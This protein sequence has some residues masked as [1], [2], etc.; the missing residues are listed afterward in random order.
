VLSKPSTPTSSQAS[1][2]HPPDPTQ[3]A[4][5]S[6]SPEHNNLHEKG[7]DWNDPSNIHNPFN[8]PD[9][10]KWRVTLLAS[11]MT[12]VI[13]ANG[14]MMTSAAQQINKSFHISDEAFPHSYWPVLS[15][16]LGGA[17]APMIGLPLRR[18][19]A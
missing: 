17:A 5:A 16:N 18:N 14:T 6:T 2:L 13:Q 4:Q 3:N 12:F 7:L 11:F 10:K 15:W 1:T 8:W 19:L 9:T